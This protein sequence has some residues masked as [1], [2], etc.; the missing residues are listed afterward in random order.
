VEDVLPDIID[1]VVLNHEDVAAVLHDVARRIDR[2]LGAP[3]AG[4]VATTGRR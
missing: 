2:V 3:A 4:A 1:R